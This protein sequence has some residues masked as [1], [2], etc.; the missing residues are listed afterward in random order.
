MTY[1]ETVRNNLKEAYPEIADELI[2]LN[3]TCE[4]D[5]IRLEV[6]SALM[7]GQDVYILFSFQDL[8]GDRISRYLFNYA[9]RFLDDTGT[10]CQNTGHMLLGFS[11]EERKVTCIQCFR[12]GAPV[13][14]EDS[15]VTAEFT[16]LRY[17][18]TG[19]WTCSRC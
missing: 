19:P 8:E 17:S 9:V 10:V 12:Y 1:E 7:K 6:Q 16:E 18:G 3:L 11:R 4:R 5:G 14:P 15:T 13:P 2:P